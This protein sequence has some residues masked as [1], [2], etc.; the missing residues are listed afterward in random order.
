MY[1]YIEETDLNNKSIMSKLDSLK[2][3]LGVEASTKLLEGIHLRLSSEGLFLE[4]GELSMQG[5]FRENIKRL[6]HA[7]LTHELLVKTAKLKDIEQP[8]L[9][10][11]TAG[12]GEDSLLLAAAGFNVELYESDK[13]IA[14][15][16]EDTI[17]RAL[18]I[19]ELNEAVSRMHLHIEDSIEAMKHLAFKPD[20]VLLDPMFP[21]RKKSG[22][23]KKKFQLMQQLEKPCSNEEE[24]LNAAFM[25][26]PR[27]I[28]IKR[29]AKGPF[30]AGKKPSY[31]VDGKAIR[32]DC[33]INPNI[34]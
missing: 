16:L 8:H 20:V 10:D 5:D 24:L 12:M 31:S 3:R 28:V 11:A 17:E 4:D 29:P 18:L 1:I 21:E 30:L 15:L 32:Y 33:I 23:I 2:E 7:N 13:V 34:V 19:P 22:L 26:K 25:S 6:T 9:I 27:K 14:S